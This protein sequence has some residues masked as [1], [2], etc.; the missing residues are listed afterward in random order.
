MKLSA[1]AYI[2]ALSL[3]AYT[4]HAGDASVKCSAA[5][6]NTEGKAITLA[7]VRIYYGRDPAALVKLVTAKSPD[8]S[9]SFTGLDAGTWYFSAKS[10]TAD[11]SESAASNVVTRVIKAALP[12]APVLE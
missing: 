2:G 1:L 8:C 12:V 4:A 7:G 9:A 3:M 5:A 11:G 10:F 6:L